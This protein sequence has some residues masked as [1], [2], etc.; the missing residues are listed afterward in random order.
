MRRLHLLALIALTAVGVL[1]STISAQAAPTDP[2]IY[3]SSFGEEVNTTF[4][5][6]VVNHQ[7]GNV[8]VVGDDGYVHQFDSKGSLAVFPA[9]SSSEVPGRGQIVIDNSGGVNQGNFYLWDGTYLRTYHADGSPIGE[10][11]LVGGSMGPGVFQPAAEGIEPA[12]PNPHGA[13]T[14]KNPRGIGVAPDGTLRLFVEFST[15]VCNCDMQ[16]VAIAPNGVQMGQSVLIPNLTLIFIPP[17]I[18]DQ[19]GNFY[20]GKD[21]YGASIERFDV[22]NEFADLGKVGLVTPTSDIPPQQL[23]VDP[24]TNDLYH[25]SGKAVNAVHEDSYTPFAVFTN[26]EGIRSSVGIGFSGDG[27]TLYLAEAGKIN[28]FHREPPSPPRDL[29]ASRVNEVRSRGAVLESSLIDGGAPTTYRFEFGTT[30]AYGVISES[31]KAARNYF[32]APAGGGITGLE[33]NTAYHFRMVATNSA[34]TTYGPDGTFKTYPESPGGGI[35]PCPNALA[36]K[37]T[38]AQ[39]LPDCRAYELAS[40]PDA[41]GYDVESYLAPGQAPFPG[42]PFA[43]DK[44]LYATHSGAV[45]GPW[46]ATNKG[47]DPYVSTRTD[48]GWVTQYEGLPSNLIPMAGS[49]SSVLGE[50][51]SSLSTLAFAGP[52]LCSPCFTG[53]GLETGIPVRMPDGQLVQG[54]AGSLSGSV[55][56]AA[57]PEGKVAKF[58]SADGTKLL[59]ASKY[60]FEPGANNNGSDLTVYERDLGVGTTEIVSTDEAGNALTGEGISELDVSTNGSR[61]VI[62]KKV[63]ADPQGNEYVHPYLHLAG[64]PGSVDLAPLASKGVLYAGMTADGAKV[65]FTSPDQLTGADTDTSADLY[66][67]D[68]DAS[69]NLALKLVSANSSDACSPVANSNGEHWNTTSSNVDCSAVAISGGGGVASQ[70]GAV[71]FLSPE[72]LGGQGT[73]NQ[74]NLYLAQPSGSISFV[75]TL[76]P[77]NPLVLD[78]V[79]ANAARRTADFQTTP[80]GNYAALTSNLNLS[81]LSTHGFR[82]AYRYSAGTGQL[83]CV[84]CDRT[85]TEE[86]AAFAVAELPPNGLGLLE[87]GRLFFTTAA[88]LVVNDAN[89]KQDVYEWSGGDPLL[90]S[91]G[92]GPF[93]SGLLTASADGTDVFFFTHDN[94]VPEE[95]HNGALMRIYDAREGGGQFRLPAGV[96]CQASDECHGPGTPQ[97]GPADIKSSGKTTQGN[98]IV[99]AKN[100]VKK[101][102]VCVK[103]NHAKKKHH[104]KKHAKKKGAAKKRAAA[105]NGKRGGRNA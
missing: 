47:P 40:A 81:S 7:T 63:S 36:R 88:Q 6:V 70:T 60:A 95:D 59:F 48:S 45:P 61:V 5:N 20:A 72:S 4:G 89:A 30:T 80:S 69:G 78:S 92:S 1:A 3:K 102:G 75:A 25:V 53:G 44:L 54:M 10:S 37:Q 29:A 74:P 64:R 99:C 66:E 52:N 87:D 62:G 46:N 56:P 55:N 23:A 86:Q 43:K 100:R 41:G 32:A 26:A 31:F 105:T 67:A 65:F 49:F 94:L 84:S 9:A 15:N 76:E 12:P 33:P 8:L 22:S 13:P 93:D 16:I 82:S 18:Y 68:V 101:R 57:K 91:A 39:R 71:Y 85:G 96:P 14:G 51:D 79:K 83:D 77:D 28:I 104:K 73:L 19:A 35:D 24:A 11:P 97:P 103:Q 2:W 17:P 34:G 58:F 90:V 42:F 38:I 98:V 21:F 27:Q 50:A